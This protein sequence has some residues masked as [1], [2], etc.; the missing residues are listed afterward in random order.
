MAGRPYFL[1]ARLALGPSSTRS[2]PV[3]FYSLRAQRLCCGTVKFR[4]KEGFSPLKSLNS[5][6]SPSLLFQNSCPPLP[7]HGSL[8]CS[9][10]HYRCKEDPTAE[11]G[12]TCQGHVVCID[13]IDRPTK[14]LRCCKGGHRRSRCTIGEDGQP[15]DQLPW[16]A[17]H[18]LWPIGPP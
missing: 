1:A 11:R 4:G 14:G 9:I 18:G 15:T 6:P 2:F 16:P 3:A 8:Q 10:H 7:Y 13:C 5:S 17:D 12:I